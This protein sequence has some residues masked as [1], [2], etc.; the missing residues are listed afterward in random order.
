MAELLCSVGWV[1]RFIYDHHEGD[2]VM[3]RG[4]VSR[5]L[6][7]YP[8]VCA[9]TRG[10]VRWADLAM[11]DWYIRERKTPLPRWYPANAGYKCESCLPGRHVKKS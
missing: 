9:T 7:R 6:K 11:E 8:H 5:I 2:Q 3:V 1:Q 10:I 4:R